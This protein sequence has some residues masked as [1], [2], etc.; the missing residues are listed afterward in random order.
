VT[1]PPAAGPR[2]LTANTRLLA[3]L[4]DPVDHSLS[5][6]FQNAA[7]EALRLDAAFLALRCDEV[8]LAGL[9]RGIAAAGGGGNVTVPHKGAAARLVDRATDAVR[10]TG[11]CNA[12]WWEDG[13]LHGDNTDVRGVSLAIRAL[14]GCSAQGM[15]VL[16]IGAGGAAAAALHALRLDGAAHVSVLNRTPG[17]ADAMIA[18]LAAGP[19]A[20]AVAVARA[21][22]ADEVFDLAI[23]ATS[24][25]MREGDPQPLP[26]HGP[27]APRI[28]AA[29]DLVY[30]PGATEW[31][32]A[33][34]RLRIPAQDGREML[35][36]QG[37]AAFERWWDRA[38][39]V[40]VMR[41]ALEAALG[42]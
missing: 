9:M 23:N 26:F 42:D 25:G 20:G 14:L 34:T 35:L 18:R 19:A 37:A 33:A 27:G 28:G 30:R 16:L 36:G 6:C 41:A 3:L 40:E 5:P 2:G 15:R 29:L 31:V 1:S 39:P 38:A 22:V 12:F 7:I 4:G 8:A 32:H 11:A 24:L 10:A 13:A 21:G 17:R